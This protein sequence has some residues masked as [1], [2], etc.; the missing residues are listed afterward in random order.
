ML[1]MI[2]IDSAAVLAVL[3]ELAGLCVPVALRRT[4]MTTWSSKPR[5]TVALT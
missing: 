4:R 2:G 1:R 3:D 5:S